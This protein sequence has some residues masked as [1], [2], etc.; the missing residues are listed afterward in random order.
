M[1]NVQFTIYN[2][3]EIVCSAL[4]VSQAVY[5]AVFLVVTFPLFLSMLLLLGVDS[6]F[7]LMESMLH[8]LRE[9]VPVLR[10][11][12]KHGV[13]GEAGSLVLNY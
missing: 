11:I 10:R 4:S 8:Q 1:Y 13:N 6:L 7:G 3:S 12:K 5:F 2:L 9:E